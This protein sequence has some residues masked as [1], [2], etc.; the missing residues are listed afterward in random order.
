MDRVMGNIDAVTMVEGFKSTK[1]HLRNE[2]LVDIKA[3]FGSRYSTFLKMPLPVQ[4]VVFD[5]MYNVGG[6]WFP[7]FYTGKGWINW[8]ID[9]FNNGNNYK[10]AA[11]HITNDA[12]TTACS[13]DKKTKKRTCGP[14]WFPTTKDRR[15]N[16]HQMLYDV[17]P[18]AYCASGWP[19]TCVSPTL[20]STSA[21]RRCADD[22]RTGFR[23]GGL[24]WGTQNQIGCYQ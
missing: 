18:A 11:D 22:R 7:K 5:I 15:T 17:G 6:K 3:A 2:C 13:T 23:F 8:L 4:Y 14:S 16:L 19:V 12:W 9:G 21:N 1:A 10:R 20:A 24:R